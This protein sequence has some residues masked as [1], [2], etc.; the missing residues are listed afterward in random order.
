MKQRL[1][2]KHKPSSCLHLT[3]VLHVAGIIEI[4]NMIYGE[5]IEWLLCPFFKIHFLIHINNV[6]ENVYT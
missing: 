1:G 2:V 3:K 6:I 4:I 5:A